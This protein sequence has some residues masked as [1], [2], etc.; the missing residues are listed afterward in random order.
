MAD[1]DR[2]KD[3]CNLLNDR[4]TL[5]R[6]GEIMQEIFYMYREKMFDRSVF[7]LE[8]AGLEA[9]KTFYIQEGH[10]RLAR[11]EIDHLQPFPKHLF[12]EDS[13]VEERKMLLAHLAS[14]LFIT[15]M[16]ELLEYFL[17]GRH[18]L[19]HTHRNQ[20]IMLSS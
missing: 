5:Y 11:R 13:G 8:T 9:F 17:M 12:E 6:I 7:S 14:P 1:W 16:N 3:I 19:S 2:H 18:P 20:Q 10:Y 4:R 15:Y